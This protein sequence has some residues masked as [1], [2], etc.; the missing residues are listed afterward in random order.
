M[1]VSFLGQTGLRLISALEL[2][3]CAPRTLITAPL[4]YKT[5]TGYS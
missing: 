3:G 5:L 2:G 4:S 1:Q